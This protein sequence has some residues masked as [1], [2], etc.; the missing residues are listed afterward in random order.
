MKKSTRKLLKTLSPFLRAR[1][2]DGQSMTRELPVSNEDM[3]DNAIKFSQFRQDMFELA[4]IHTGLE[5][6]FDDSPSAYI[7]QCEFQGWHK[8]L[9][10]FA[11]WLI[12]INKERS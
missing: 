8:D 1:K 3:V 12:D 9:E 11:N 2:G 10:V 5:P 4:M 6:D 7:A